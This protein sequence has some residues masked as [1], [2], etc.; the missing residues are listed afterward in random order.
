MATHANQGTNGLIFPPF[1]KNFKHCIDLHPYYIDSEYFMVLVLSR[2]RGLLYC[3]TALSKLIHN[4]QSGRIKTSSVFLDKLY[5]QLWMPKKK[6]QSN[7]TSPDLVTR[8]H[9]MNIQGEKV[10]LLLQSTAFPRSKISL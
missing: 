9:H 5:K 10:I 4:S 7:I 6:K 8:T 3:C 2:S 1:F